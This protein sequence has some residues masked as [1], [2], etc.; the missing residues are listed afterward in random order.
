MRTPV[1]VSQRSLF[2]IASLVL[3]VL[4]LFVV[5]PICV[6]DAN[7]YLL[8]VR[9]FAAHGSPDIRAGDV[10]A[11]IEM[12]RRNRVTQ[13]LSLDPS[14]HLGQT[15]TTGSGR[16]CF[17]HFWFYSLLAM[18]LWL[19][20]RAVG[21]NEMAVLQAMNMLYLCLAVGMALFLGSEKRRDRVWLL[22]LSLV[23]PVIWYL[24]WPHPE[25]FT[26]G[27]VLAA[28][29]LL[30]AER[31]GWAALAASLGALQNPPVALLGLLALVLAAGQRRWRSCAAAAV[32]TALAFLPVVW[33]LWCFGVTNLMVARGVTDF[34]LVS[35]ARVWSVL[36][37]L[38]QGMLPYVPATLLL[39]L[40]GGCLALARGR[41]RGILILLALLGMILLVAPQRNW[42]AGCA[43]MM[44]Y[45]IW[46]VPLLA[47]LA[48]DHLPRGRNLTLV[49]AAG[50]LLQVAILIGT[51]D[52]RDYLRQRAA[53]R[54]VLSHWPGLYSP[55]PQIFVE[56]QMGHDLDRW[57]WRL[58]VPFVTGEGEVT[59][60]LV[61]RGSHQRLVAYFMVG[62]GGDWIGEPRSGVYY[63]DPPQGA[64]LVVDPAGME[65]DLFRRQLDIRLVEQSLASNGTELEVQVVITNSGPHRYWGGDSETPR[66]LQLGYRLSRGG[67]RLRE[68]RAPMPFLLR[69]GDVVERTLR[70]EIPDGPG[71][72]D[73]EIGTL[74]RGLVWSDSRMQLVVECPPA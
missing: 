73:L 16:S 29:V 39:G 56:R 37:D 22:L 46:M 71:G 19:L 18:P 25:V 4:A 27:A 1:T 38:N 50:L 53:A 45:A 21:G 44:R 11:H 35:T 14:Y 61:D 33:S 67:E 58:P 42:N 34:S 65:P 10:D 47:W 24:L 69:P 40:G 74:L 26:W 49:T 41:W 6:G 5:P 72:C 57:S 9:A 32:G 12:L 20:I 52:P 2:I 31:Y 60:L 59:K 43:G 36:V 3:V 7:E 55:D 62:A 17:Q 28:V 54:F 64:L 23:G 13:G 68:G 30:R 51:E 15:H 66:P 70:I 8:M 63:L 48:V